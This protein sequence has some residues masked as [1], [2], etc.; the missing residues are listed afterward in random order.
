MG[1]KTRIGIIVVAFMAV[2]IAGLLFAGFQREELLREQLDQTAIGGSRALWGKIV[3]TGIQRMRELTPLVERHAALRSALID[4]DRGLI[5]TAA[6]NVLAALRSTGAVTRLDLVS[7]S[8]EV[9]YSSVPA[10][11]PT[12]AASEE[13]LTA[14]IAG[15]QGRSGVAI[16]AARNVTLSAGV[17][18][19]ADDGTAAGGGHLCHRHRAGAVRT[20]GGHR[21]RGVDREPAR[22]PAGRHRSP[23]LGGRER[24]GVAPGSRRAGG[25][26][27]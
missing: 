27:R 11:E 14:M 18:L 2:M 22:P 9:L 15:R 1:I 3:E 20:E 12:A 16:D 17:L 26:Q 10:F 7:L 19:Y 25:A 6:G 8:H 23:D 24:V 21:R 13:A 5:S 4:N